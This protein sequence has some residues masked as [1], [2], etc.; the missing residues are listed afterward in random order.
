M[1]N[2]YKLANPK[3]NTGYKGVRLSDDNLASF[4]ERLLDIWHKAKIIKIVKPIK[5]KDNN[6]D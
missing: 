2:S 1:G 4:P 3:R 5:N 6:D